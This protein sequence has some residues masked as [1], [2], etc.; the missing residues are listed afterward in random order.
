MSQLR[1]ARVVQFSVANF[2]DVITLH[3]VTDETGIEMDR[4][5]ALTPN[6]QQVWNLLLAAGA[7]MGAYALLDRLKGS[8]FKAPLQVYRALEKLV[9]LA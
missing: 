4:D 3:I 7:P 5:L 6:Q 9:E 1:V 2:R 8:N